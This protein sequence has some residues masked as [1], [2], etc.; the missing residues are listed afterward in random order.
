M[1][2][3]VGQYHLNSIGG[4]ETFTYTLVKELVRQGH[5]VDLITF[6]PGFLSNMLEQETG[7]PT[8]VIR[9]SHYDIALVNHNIVVDKIRSLGVVENIIQTCH[10]IIPN[11]EFPTNNANKHIAISKEIEDNI[12]EKGFTNTEIILNGIDCNRFNPVI[13]L[14]SRIRNIVS[15]S[16][17]ESANTTLSIVCNLLGCN[18]ITFNKNTNPTFAIEKFINQGDLVVG[19]GRSAYDAIACGRPVFVWDERDYQGNLGDGYLTVDNFDD[20]AIN[21]CSGRRNKKVYTPEL[22]AKEILENYNSNDMSNYRQLALDKLN[23]EKQVQK[24]LL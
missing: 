9:E 23:I 22:I 11:L 24:Y 21:N 10:G 4:T 1:K 5:F 12:N 8:N 19:L 7:I 2:I 3:L 15:L 18:L 16:Q 6:V 17:S 20:F 14:N 13:T